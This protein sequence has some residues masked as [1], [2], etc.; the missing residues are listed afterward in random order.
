MKIEQQ[1]ALGRYTL[2]RYTPIKNAHAMSEKRLRPPLS[3]SSPL[4]T[5]FLSGRPPEG[6]LTL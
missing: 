4:L 6:S 2:G 5:S 1:Q 3:P